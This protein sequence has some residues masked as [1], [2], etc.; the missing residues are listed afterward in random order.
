MKG[1]K[2]LKNDVIN[3][4]NISS[5][6]AV[7][8]YNSDY[9]ELLESAND[10]RKS[11]VG[12]SFDICTIIN[13]KSGRCSENCRYCAQSS[14]YNTNIEEYPLLRKDNITRAA[15]E[16]HTGGVLRFSIVT[17]GRDLNDDEIDSVCE[18]FKNIGDKCSIDL[19]ASHGLL[20]LK[21]FKKL[22]ESGV[23]RYH[24]NL[25]TSRRFFNRIC[26]THTY[27]EKIEAIK[28]AK[29]A[30]LKVCSGGI[31]GLGE[32]V[33]D[34]IDMVMEIKS[35]DIKSIPV[36]ILNPIKGTPLEY[37]PILSEEEI[38][39]SIA[40]FRFIVPDGAIRLAG[41]RALLQDKGKKAFMS[42]ANA[43][44]SGNML[45]TLGITLEEDIKMITSCGY[46]IEKI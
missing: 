5:S 15:I 21:Q 14:F 12:E 18:S 44:I 37:M 7:S 9:E 28:R 38:L 10:I 1:L 16:N 17:S 22:K 4:Y 39:R 23:T 3:G 45:T 19:C 27:D 20:S 32:D 42:G 30:G 40:T 11:L 29:S 8:I 13:G 33:K 26:T 2:D 31:L 34:R 6:E 43:A 46:R 35:L 25:E 24:N 41:G 36:N